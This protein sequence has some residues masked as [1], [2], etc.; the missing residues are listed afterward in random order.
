MTRHRGARGAID[1]ASWRDQRPETDW[2][3]EYSPETFT[4]TELEFARDVCEAV[5]D[6]WQPTPAR[7]VILNLPATVEVATPNIYAGSDR[8][9][10][11]EHQ[12]ARQRRD[13]APSAQRP[14]H[15]RGGG[16]ARAH[17]GRGSRR[18]LPV[19]QRRADRQRRP[20]DAGAQPLH[21]GHP[22]RAGF[23]R[24]QR[25]VRARW[26]TA[27]SCRSIR[28]TLTWAISSSPRSPVRTRTRS[29]R[30]SPRSEP[31]ALWEVPYL[32]IDPADVGRTYEIGDPR[33]QP[34]GQGRRRLPARARLWHRAAARGCR[35]SSARRC[36][37]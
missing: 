5:L 19:R 21:P 17:G 2:R 25:D 13:L 16:G 29:R 15:R 12:P 11:P 31:D 30:A 22:S 27:T 23:L 18:G 10:A 6:V 24:H 7:K 36:R 33:E 28:A 8:M 32:P 35:S 20:R 37:R 26:N 34:V 14:R 3:F 9:D 4:A 1:Q